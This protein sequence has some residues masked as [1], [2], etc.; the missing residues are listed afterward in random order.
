MNASMYWPILSADIAFQ[1]RATAITIFPYIKTLGLKCSLLSVSRVK[2]LNNKIKSA[3]P[4]S[5]NV[6]ILNIVIFRTSFVS[7]PLS[8]T[9]DIKADKNN[10]QSCL[11]I[12]TAG[13]IHHEPTCI[14]CTPDKKSPFIHTAIKISTKDSYKC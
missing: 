14:T 9:I 5:A 3:R 8:P 7:R 12:Y 4:E 2:A 13:K 11:G 1:N 10:I 6:E